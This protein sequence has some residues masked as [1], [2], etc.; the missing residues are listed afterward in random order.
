MASLARMI[1]KCSLITQGHGDTGWRIGE[2][3]DRRGGVVCLGEWMGVKTAG[4]TER[5]SGVWHRIHYM[6]PNSESVPIQRKVT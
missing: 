3:V 4:E 5:P 1:D 2:R 6:G